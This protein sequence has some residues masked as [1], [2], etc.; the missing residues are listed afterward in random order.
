MPFILEQTNFITRAANAGEIFLNQSSEALMG[1]KVFT[2]V[3]P[4][5]DC[6]LGALLLI[7]YPLRGERLAK[8]QEKV[9]TLHMNKRIQ[10]E[11]AFSEEMD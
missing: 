10:F 11:K 7:W 4:G 3:I 6:L 2:G 5:L 8:V 1:I 9:L